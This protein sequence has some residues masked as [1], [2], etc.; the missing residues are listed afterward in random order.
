MKYKNQLLKKY[1]G[2]RHSDRLKNISVAGATGATLVGAVSLQTNLVLTQNV[3]ADAAEKKQIKVPS[4]NGKNVSEFQ[5]WADEQ[6][7]KLNIETVDSDKDKNTVISDDQSKVAVGDTIN[8][9][10]SKGKDQGQY[11]VVYGD[12]LWA[13]G[14]KYGVN[15]QDVAKANNIDVA[16]H[17][18]YPGQILTIPNQNG[19]TNKDSVSTTTQQA[20][21]K[22]QTQT[23]TAPAAQSQAPAATY[24]APVTQ[25]PAATRA[26]GSVYDQFIANGGTPAMWTYI[27]MPESGGNPDIVSPNGYHGLG[28]TKQYWGYGDVATQTQGMINYANQRYGSIDNAIAFRQAHN[29]W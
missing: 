17:F 1:S 12:S 2:N 11:T 16:T 14:E 25:A 8:V 29:W 18:I 10:V 13:I 22:Q 27:V 7:V 24:Q 5:K 3:K 26:S 4:F 6:N 23:Y 15:W 19:Q 21:I 9:K 28:Q 20:T